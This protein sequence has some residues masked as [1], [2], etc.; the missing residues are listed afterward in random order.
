MADTLGFHRFAI[1]GQ[2]MGAS[3][4]MKA[5][6][7]DGSRL[8]ALVLVDV[9]GRVDPGV[10]PVIAGSLARLGLVDRLGRRVRG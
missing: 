5:A 10:G 1:V 2:S 4:A 9:A 8:R 7:L 6:E 3:V